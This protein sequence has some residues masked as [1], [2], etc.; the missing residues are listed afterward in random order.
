M[1]TV[2]LLKQPTGTIFLAPDVRSTGVA[3]CLY[4]LIEHVAHDGSVSQ[5]AKYDGPYH[6]FRY[7]LLTGADSLCE[8]VMDRVC[9][10]SPCEMSHR[11]IVWDKEDIH[12][13]ILLIAPDYP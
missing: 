9:G 3:G 10:W 7:R 5:K 2:E 11:F 4:Q 13:L 12:K 1:T 6:G 8:L